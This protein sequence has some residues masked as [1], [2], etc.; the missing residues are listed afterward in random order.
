MD[1]TDER[2]GP[3]A[4]GVFARS[5]WTLT[6]ALV[7]VLALA[8]AACGS[9]GTNDAT[10]SGSPN[11]A[12]DDLGSLS[13]TLNGSGSTFQ[14]PFDQAVI[15]GFDQRVPKVTINYAGGG[16]GKGKQ[17]LASR[18]VDFAGTDSLVKD[19]DRAT[20]K[21][22]QVL[23]FPTVAAPITVA[24]HLPVEELKLDGAVLARIFSLQITHWNDAA[25]AALNPGAKLPDTRI[26]VVHRSDA[27]GTTSNFTKYLVAAAGPAWTLGTSDVVNWPAGTQAGQGNA[28]VAQ[29]VQST[30]GAVGYVDYSDAVNA[31]LAFASVKNQAGEFQ[32]PTLEGASAAVGGATVKPDLTYDPLNAPGTG[33]YPITSPTWIV[34]YANQPSRGKG[35]ALEAFLRYVLTDGQQLAEPSSYAALPDGLRQ[36]AIA[37]LD[38]IKVATS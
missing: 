16:S 17:E 37:Q 8:A 15:A 12:S 26:T 19:A 7:A 28:G 20:F 9:T 33:V 38:Q 30:D 14:M 6:V 21:G 29:I 4:S 3:S 36:K 11:G 31:K 24:Y 1:T 18:V 32:Q 2:Q 10:G 13:A 27:S 5:R 25:I 22:G 23:Y 35:E 34:V